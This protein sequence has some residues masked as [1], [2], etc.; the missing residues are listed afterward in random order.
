MA[1]NGRGK[2]LDAKGSLEATGEESTERSDDR[3]EQRQEQRVQLKGIEI[4]RALEQRE[5][6]GQEM[7]APLEERQ[8]VTRGGQ[9][10]E[11]FAV[12]QRTDEELR[13]TEDAGEDEAEDESGDAAADEAFPGLLW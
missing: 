8:R 12:F 3:C 4:E 1:W 6:L 7:R 10:L 13:A 2:V 5:R 11:F 9:T